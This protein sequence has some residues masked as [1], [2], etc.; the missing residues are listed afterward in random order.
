MWK[1]CEPSTVA[2]TVIGVNGQLSIIH[3]YYLIFDIENDQH[4]HHR[5]YCD[6]IMRETIVTAVVVIVIVE[7]GS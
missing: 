5:E 3:T 1:M 6:S 2:H 4:R 7:A